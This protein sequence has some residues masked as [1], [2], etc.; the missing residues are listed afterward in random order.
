MPDNS[1]IHDALFTLRPKHSSLSER[2]LTF[3]AEKAFMNNMEVTVLWRGSEHNP[4]PVRADILFV[5]DK[6]EPVFS[7]NINFSLESSFD[8]NIW[9]NSEQ[10]TGLYRVVK[11][12]ETGALKEFLAD[13]ASTLNSTQAPID[14]SLES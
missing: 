1:A 11:L 13:L 14:P 4:H 12:N 3:I 9:G 6:F 8:F 5:D 10:H 2:I 7:G